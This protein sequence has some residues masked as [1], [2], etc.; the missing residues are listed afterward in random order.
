MV[1][2]V[3]VVVIALMTAEAGIRGIVVV[4]VDMAFG[5]IHIGVGAV[6]R[7]NWSMVKG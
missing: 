6:Q 1:G 3:R 2:I 7:P 5:T 4:A